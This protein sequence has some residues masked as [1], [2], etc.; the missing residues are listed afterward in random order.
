[1]QARCKAIKNRVKAV[2][3]KVTSYYSVLLVYTKN[4]S[5]K[6]FHLADHNTER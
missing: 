1:M 6:I 4:S 3:T 2:K 5:I